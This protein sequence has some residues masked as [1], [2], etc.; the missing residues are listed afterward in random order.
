MTVIDSVMDRKRL[1]LVKHAFCAFCRQR[2]L[3]EDFC[4]DAVEGIL[5]LCQGQ[6]SQQKD[7]RYRSDTEVIT[8][9]GLVVL[10]GTW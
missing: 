9:G 8:N 6:H 5:R 10:I 7:K 2:R 3:N 1:W 4:L